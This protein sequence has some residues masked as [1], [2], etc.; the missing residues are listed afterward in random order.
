MRNTMNIEQAGQAASAAPAASGLLGW[1]WWKLLGMAGGVG[2]AAALAVFIVMC[3]TRPRDD[4]EWRVA[5]ASTLASSIFGGAALIRYMGLQVW[6]EDWFGA[7]G[8]LGVVFSCGLPGWSIV[9]W[10]FNF[11]KKNE[12][13]G[14]DEMI[15]RARRTAAGVSDPLD[16]QEA[17]HP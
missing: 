17:G 3:M 11:A 9:R 2:F 7:V 16:E 10:W 13:R 1:V 5:L 12:D 15:A 4:K 6:A 8:L 14:L